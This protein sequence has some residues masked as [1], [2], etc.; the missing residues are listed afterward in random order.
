MIKLRRAVG[1]IGA[2]TLILGGGVAANSALRTAAGVLAKKCTLEDA[3]HPSDE[4]DTFVLSAGHVKGNPHHLVQSLSVDDLLNR[5]RAQFSYI[6]IDM[7]PILGASEA[8][9][10][11]KAADAVLFCSLC[12]VSRSRQVHAAVERLENAGAN[13]VGAIL[14]GTPVSRYSYVYGYYSDQTT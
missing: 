1:E 3:I 8:L 11:A 5:L 7:P 2:R 9:V 14:S 4:A 6:V 13:V 10:F 12:D